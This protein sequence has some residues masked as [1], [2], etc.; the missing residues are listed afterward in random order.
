MT[1]SAQEQLVRLQF[2]EEAQDYVEEIE[3]GLIGLGTG[4]VK[5]KQLDAVMRAAHSI[6]GGAAMM[7]FMTLSKIGHRLE[8]SLKV[9][10]SGKKPEL[11]DTQLEKELLTVVDRLRQVMAYNRQGQDIPQDWLEQEVYPRLER[12]YDRLGDPQALEDTS[13]LGEEDSED[14]ILVYLFESE[15]E[16]ALAHLENCLAGADHSSLRSELEITTETLNGLAEMVE[17]PAMAALCQD[18]ALKLAQFPEH[19]LAI[20]ELAIGAWRRSQSLVLVGQRDCLPTALDPLPGVEVI[21]QSDRGSFGAIEFPV[22][23][24]DI[25]DDSGLLENA[26]LADTLVPIANSNDLELVN[27][28]LVNFPDPLEAIAPPETPSAPL[29]D[30]DDLGDLFAA[31]LNWGELPE[32]MDLSSDL[33]DFHDVDEL[34]S[35]EEIAQA[36][37]LPAL[38]LPAWAEPDTA[39]DSL[40]QPAAL[41]EL[42]LTDIVPVAPALVHPD[43]PD[44]VDTLAPL[45]SLPELEWP[46]PENGLAPLVDDDFLGALEAIAAELTPALNPPPAAAGQSRRR[47]AQRGHELAGLADFEV[48]REPTTSEPETTAIDEGPVLPEQM[49]RV[50]VNQLAEMGDLFGEINIGRSAMNLQITGIRGL[51]E[52][53]LEKVGDLE[54]ASGQLRTAYDQIATQ[55]GTTDSTTSL[56]DDFDHLEM[57]HYGE[58]HLLSQSVMEAVVQIQE[59]VTDIELRLNDTETVTREM[60]RTTRQMQKRIT[61]MRMLP[62]NDVVS[63]FPRALQDLAAAHGKEVQVHISGGDLLLERNVLDALKDPLMHIVRNCF[64]HGLETPAERL[65]AGKATTGH[66][67]VAACYRGNQTVITIQDDGRGMN[68]DKIRAKALKMGID[69]QTLATVSEQDLLELVFEPGFSTAE[70]VTDLSGRGVGMDVVR[71]NI[72]GV[73]G[74]IQLAT[75]SGQGSTFTIT[76]PFDLSVVKV[77]VVESDRLLFAVPVNA[78]DEM[79]LPPWAQVVE[80]DGQQILD[81][82]DLHLPVLPLRDC[83]RSYSPLGT[84]EWHGVPKIDQP[85]L[86]LLSQG[87]QL[88]GLKIDRFWQEQEVTVRQP[89]GVFPL[90]IGLSGCAILG[91]GRILPLLDPITLLQA[92]SSS[93]TQVLT[94]T[95]ISQGTGTELI[96]SEQVILVIDDSINVRR[97]V[98]LTL[99]RNGYRVEQ[100]K[101]GLE[102]L[103]KV[104]AG[105]IPDAVI[106]DVEMPRMDGYGFLANVKSIPAAKQV[107]VVMLTS[108]SGQKHR[109]L[110]MTLGAADYFAKP[111]NEAEMIATLAKLIVASP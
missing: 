40:P 70:Q 5:G 35:I 72:Q 98:A 2:L 29:I 60:D 47:Q 15:V 13:L 56:T 33:P 12:L 104:Q 57:D 3:A 53:L 83:F 80:Q 7:N 6:K 32:E 23:A 106:C 95:T 20:A 110:A 25:I 21:G 10:R 86:L 41:T 28:E 92:I 11:V 27:F 59:K 58:F 96:S 75:Q 87:E 26:L 66:I 74:T 89:Q 52:G 73:Q 93:G 111:F 30:S 55:L 65:L 107:P 102:A 63:R 91:D 61:G 50:G 19:F 43:Q 14:D 8:D 85:A 79:M 54:V 67:R 22:P 46:E 109:K 103:E 37:A 62:F 77:L 39:S 36:A 94:D 99:E 4:E 90:P 68:L 71:T 34:F 108:R 45:P 44:V 49:L 64:D 9:L 38:N 31:N 16:G 48:L 97:F 18:V 76:V 105:L 88:L 1:I 42:D 84:P 51:L 17:L 100:A 82:E 24:A 101:D 78:V 69:E 81:W